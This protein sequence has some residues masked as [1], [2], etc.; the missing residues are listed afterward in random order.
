MFEFLN[1]RGYDLAL[2]YG[3]KFRNQ[4]ALEEDEQSEPEPKKSIMTASKLIE[5]LDTH[6][7]WHQSVWEQWFERAS[8]VNNW[9]RNYEDACLQWGDCKLAEVFVSPDSSAWLIQVMC[10][11]SCIATCTT[12]HWRWWPKW[13]AIIQGQWMRRKFAFPKAIS[14]Q[15]GGAMTS[16]PVP[17]I[18]CTS[19]VN[20]CQTLSTIVQPTTTLGLHYNPLN[21]SEFET[22]KRGIYRPNADNI[23]A[24]SCQRK[25][26]YQTVLPSIDPNRHS[27]RIGFVYFLHTMTFRNYWNKINWN[28]GRKLMNSSK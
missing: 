28:E 24:H 8:G 1:S 10:R 7:S 22:F 5:G 6:W 3:V 15:M 16:Q 19:R 25:G 11:E 18:H 13:P 26:L 27:S 4:R 20:E 2:D 21:M 12:R 17:A 14:L 23:F 9:A